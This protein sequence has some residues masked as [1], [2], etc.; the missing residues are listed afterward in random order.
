MR[1][2]TCQCVGRMPRRSTDWFDAAFY[3]AGPLSLALLLLTI[4]GVGVCTALTRQ[5]A[6]SGF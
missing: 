3:V 2:N 1:R 6:L 5:N 4:W